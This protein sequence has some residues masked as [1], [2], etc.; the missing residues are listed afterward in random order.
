VR[1]WGECHCVGDLEVGY[2]SCWLS[3][4]EFLDNGVGWGID[5]YILV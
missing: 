5:E 1:V 2:W 4:F 3:D